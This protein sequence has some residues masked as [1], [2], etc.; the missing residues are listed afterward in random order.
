MW[1][2][3]RRGGGEGGGRLPAS[4]K[5]AHDFSRQNHDSTAGR[6]DSTCLAPLNE[7]Y[8]SRRSDSATFTALEV[9]LGLVVPR[10]RVSRRGKETAGTVAREDTGS[11]PL[12]GA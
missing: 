9:H 6:D 1:L 10:H 4:N 7:Q 8:V 11:N 12:M 3:E 5:S 2:R